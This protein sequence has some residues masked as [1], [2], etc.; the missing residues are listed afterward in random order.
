M[1]GFK[2]VH[3][4]LSQNPLISIFTDCFD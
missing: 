3:A 2:Y 4:D 1:A